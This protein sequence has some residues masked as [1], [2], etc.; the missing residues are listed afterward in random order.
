[1]EDGTFDLIGVGAGPSNLALAIAVAERAESRALFLERSVRFGW[2][3]DMLLDDTTMQV[4]FLKD[5]VTLRNPT[6]DFSFLS[7]LH[8]RARL[9]DFINHKTLFPLREEF[10]DYL[11]W[12]AARVADQIRYD[13]EVLAVRPVRSGRD[14]SRIA[15]LEVLARRG[16]GT[17]VSA[18]T[19]NLVVGTGLVPR[20]PD[21]VSTS[22]RI[23]HNAHML[24]RLSDLDPV[25]PERFVVVGAGQSAAEV[26]AYLHDRYPDTEVCAVFARFGYSPADD[27]PY[28]NRVFDPEAVEE[29]YAAP[30]D[31]KR[32]ILD[33]HGNTNYSVVDLE[34]IQDLYHREYREK[35]L[36]RQRLRCFNVS[37]V[38]DV[39][40]G[41]DGLSVDIISMTTG[42]KTQ[43]TA[44]AIVFCTGYD[45][46]DPATLLGN[47]VGHC[48][49][50]LDG[51]YRVQRDYRL[52]TSPELQAG[53]Y[54]QGGTEHSHGLTSSL[55][56]NIAIRAGEILDSVSRRTR[57]LV[58]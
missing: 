21:G 14:G 51:R 15:E 24:T 43:L 5:L 46:V 49:R 56:S 44:D 30:A 38:A 31:V 52:E 22:G 6:S 35:V 4:S 54:L 10:H 26:T 39:V 27:S 57:S 18:R 11:T 9:V 17:T 37:R 58:G 8:A 41:P 36:G 55:L 1:M 32:M 13:H 45:P 40:E 50:D 42:Q 3:R 47:L 28:A 12:V 20:L 16:D 33:Y 19:R 25:A 34:L 53:I 29:F 48:R 7:Y 2:H 23:W